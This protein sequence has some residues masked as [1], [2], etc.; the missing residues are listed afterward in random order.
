MDLKPIEQDIV[1]RLKAI[2][3]PNNEVEIQAFPDNPNEYNLIH[4]GG[5]LLVRFNG[6]AYQTPDPN[7][8]KFLTQDGL[9][10]WIIVEMQRNLSLKGANQGVY[11]LIES[12]RAA[13]TGYTISTLSDAS[14]MYPTGVQ[15][16]SEDQGKWVYQSSFVFSHPDHE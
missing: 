3:A 14:V 9:F 2:V 8:Q 13:L 10:Q 4:P 15:F 7:N 6:I 11:E 1:T 16:V 12:V 5:A